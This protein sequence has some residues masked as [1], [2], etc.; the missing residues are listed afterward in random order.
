MI[1][2]AESA[3]GARSQSPAGFG[4]ALAAIGRRRPT[5][6]DELMGSLLVL[7]HQDVSAGLR[8]HRTFS[9]RFYGAGPMTSSMIAQDGA[10][11]SRQRRIHNRFFS[12]RASAGYAERIAP[13][14]ARTFDA[15][16]G[17]TE[18]ELVSAAIARYPMEVFL[19]LLGVPDDLGDQ[20]LEWVRTIVSWLGSPMNEELAGPG[21]EAFAE[22]S[23]YTATLVDQERA[24]PGDNMLGEIIR[25]HLL[26]GGF[27]TEACAV[28]VVNLL[29][30]GFETT[31][32]MLSG[33][34]ASLLCNPD[35]LA[36]VAADRSLCD[37]AIDE[38]FRWASPT[39][40]LYRLVLRDVEIAGTPV[41]AGDMVYLCVAAAHHDEEA[42]VRPAEFD[43]G[44]TTGNL[45]FGLGPHYCVGAP[46]A[47]IEARA[48]LNAMLDRFPQLRLSPT[49]P[50]SFH[51]GARG[52]VQHG[53]EALPVL[54][55]AE[56]VSSR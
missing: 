41:A 18:T 12:P 45:G 34:I 37:A 48:A 5:V 4:Q 47:K 25:A 28:A 15:L 40:G 36:A 53:T 50:L 8:D 7:R 35:V 27:A 26:E 21:Q 38:A 51:Y 17:E 10:E 16:V 19:D 6:F 31:I 30:G 54:L 13:I 46:L 55:T 43:L 23:A 52:F 22:L 11:H 24:D 29:L 1:S 44:R 33:T 49:E 42:Y 14:A 3:F 32:Q 2:I 20:G 39:A 9:T 56:A